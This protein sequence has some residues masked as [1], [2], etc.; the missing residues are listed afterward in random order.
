MRPWHLAVAALDIVPLVFLCVALESEK[1]VL[2]GVGSVVDSPLSFSFFV[3][4]IVCL[5]VSVC[6]N[7]LMSYYVEDLR[8]VLLSL[9]G[10]I[11]HCA[12][13]LMVSPII[14]SWRIAHCFLAGGTCP[15]EGESPFFVKLTTPAKWIAFFLLLIGYGYWLG[16]NFLDE[17]RLEFEEAGILATVG[18]GLIIPSLAIEHVRLCLKGFPTKDVQQLGEDIVASIPARV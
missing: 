7:L 2:S 8:I 1:W 15:D 6:G 10:A 16:A 4:G 9:V 18:I 11:F 3:A 14:V 17:G 12:V 13:V 5:G